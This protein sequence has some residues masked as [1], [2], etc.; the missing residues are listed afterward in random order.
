MQSPFY[1]FFP[2]VALLE[3]WLCLRGAAGE[4][5]RLGGFSSDLHPNLPNPRAP[6]RKVPD[7]VP[8]SSVARQKKFATG[9][10]PAAIVPTKK[11]VGWNR[12]GSRALAFPFAGILWT[13]VAKHR[14]ADP[15][16]KPWT[17]K[18]SDDVKE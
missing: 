17:G 11:L 14:D 5:F 12:K 6:Q 15:P 9:P 10:I 7:A 16:T 18:V 4:T 1:T 2:Q 13:S 8:L 3:A